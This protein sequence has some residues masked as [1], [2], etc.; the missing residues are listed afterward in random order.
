MRFEQSVNVAG[1]YPL[2]A[3]ISTSIAPRPDIL[4]FHIGPANRLRGDRPAKEPRQRADQ[5]RTLLFF[6]DDRLHVRQINHH[7]D[8]G[9]AD[10]RES[11][12][13]LAAHVEDD[14]G[15]ELCRLGG[16][17]RENHGDDDKLTLYDPASKSGFPCSG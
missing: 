12:G 3:L 15:L 9:G 4:F 14:G 2:L 11:L 17:C 8:R 5:E 1:F 6:E 10:I 16:A 13:D 7:A